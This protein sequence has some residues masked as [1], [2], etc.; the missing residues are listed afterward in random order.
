MKQVV[1]A[2]VLAAAFLSPLSR[3][4]LLIREDKDSADLLSSSAAF[5][6]PYKTSRGP[7]TH[8]R[9]TRAFGMCFWH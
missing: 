9:A 1:T 7:T 8:V 5:T 6:L 2:A 3:C 4:Q